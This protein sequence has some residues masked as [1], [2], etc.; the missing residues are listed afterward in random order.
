MGLCTRFGHHWTSTT[1]DEHV[2]RC[3][4]CM[5]KQHRSSGG[6]WV[7]VSKDHVAPSRKTLP[8]QLSFFES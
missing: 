4:R 2:R 3:S 5:K 7:D 8:G 6:P 1:R